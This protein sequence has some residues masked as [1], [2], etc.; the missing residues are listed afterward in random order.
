MKYWPRRFD[1]FTGLPESWGWGPFQR[2]GAFTQ[3][4][5]LPPVRPN[6]ELVTGFVRPLNSCLTS[7]PTLHN[8][9]V[10]QID[11]VPVS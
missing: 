7:M 5:I 3:H 1:T 6:V 10:L 11:S 4:G 8:S 9:R 2:A